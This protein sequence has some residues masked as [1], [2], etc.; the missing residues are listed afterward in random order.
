MMLFCVIYSGFAQI[1]IGSGT[2]EDQN[3]PFEPFYDY[4]YAQSIYLASEIGATGSITTVSFFFSGTTALPNS[5][6]LVLYMGHTAKTSFANAADFIPVANLTQVYTQTAYPLP[7]V[8]G[9]I[10]LTLT[11]PFAY[12]GTSNLVVAVDENAPG[13]DAITDDFRNTAV[14]GNR[15]VYFFRDGTDVLPTDPANAAVSLLSGVASFVPNIIFG[16]IA[17]ACPTPSMVVA[18]SVTATSATI[19]WTETSL[20]T[21]GYDYIVSTS[22]ITPGAASTATASSLTNP[23]TLTGLTPNTNYFIYVRRK[24][25]A[26]LNSAWSGAGTFRTLC[27][28]ITNLPWAEGFD[29]IVGGTD[30]FPGCWGFTNI[31]SNWA[32]STSPTPH[33][34]TN[35]LRRT[36]ST[37]GWAYTPNFSLTAGTAYEFSYWLRA[38]DTTAPGYFID[39]AVGAS[40][41]AA[42]MTN[43][44]DSKT[45]YVN[46]DWTKVTILFTPTTTGNYVF[47]IRAGTSSFAPNGINF[48]SFKL[49]T[50]ST[51][52]EPTGLIV[53]G[54]T[55][56]GGQVDWVEPTTPAALGYQYIITTTSTFPPASATPTGSVSAG[57]NSAIFSGLMPNT[58]YFVWVRSRCSA[59]N[60]GPWSD[61]R[62]FLTNCADVTTFSQNF[63]AGTTFPACWKKL[64][65]G[66]SAFIAANGQSTPNALNIS[67][68]GATVATQGLV[69]MPPVSNAGAGTHRLR[70]RARGHFAAGSVIQV[71]YVADNFDAS[72]FV[73]VQS[74]TTTSTTI[75]DSFIAVLGTAPGTNKFL[76]F[77]NSGAPAN[78]TILLDDVSW[79][80][81]PNCIEPTSVASSNVT[82]NSAV[83]SWIEPLVPAGSGYE[84]FTST[85]NTTPSAASV[86]T[87]SVGAGIST[88]TITSLAP[89][90]A[91]FV[92]VRSVCSS[93]NKSPWTPSITFTTLCAPF[94]TLNQDFATFRPACFDFSGAGTLAS[95]PTGTSLGLWEADGFLNAGATGAVKIN[96]YFTNRIGWMISP[97]M[98][99]TSGSYTF[100]FNYGVTTWNQT[101]PSPMG[102]DDSV[103]VLITTNGGTTWSQ[104]NE[105]T[106]ASNVS[107]TANI[108]SY[109]VP[110]ASSTANVRFA[111]LASDGTVDDSPDYDFFVDNFRVQLTPTCINPT[112]VVAS[113]ITS[114]AASIAWT[115]PSPAPASGYEYFV[116]TTNATPA[117]TATPTGSTSAGV[118][119][120][121]LTTL[122]AATTYFVWVRSVCTSSDKSEWSLPTTFTTLC[123]AV[124]TF[125][126]NFDAAAT[127][128]T[129][130]AKVGTS[131]TAVIVTSG[132]AST[133]N[134]L[135]INSSSATMRAVVSMP[136]V[137]NINAGTHWLRFKARSRFSVGGVIEVGYLTNTSN[138]ASF[139][140]IQSFTTTSTTV[141]N[142]FASFLGTPPATAILAFRHTGIPAN[143]VLID[144]VSWELL[145]ACSEPTGLVSSNV[146]ATTATVSWTASASVPANGYQYFVSTTNTAPSAS[147]TPTGSTAAGVTSVN[148]TGLTSSTNYFVWVRSVCSGSSTSVWTLSPLTFTT[149]CA[150]FTTLNQNFATFPPQCIS[151]AGAGTVATGP[152]GTAPGIWEADGF[153]N[154]GAAGA[155]KVNLYSTNRIGWMISPTMNLTGGNYTLSFDYGV[156]TWNQ[157]TP[158]TMGS[159]DSV[160]VVISTN[161]GT[162]WTQIS[163]FTA[164]SNVSNV[165]NTYTYSIPVAS[166]TNNVRFA[167][168]ATDG[169][170]AD[171]QDYDFFVDNFKVEIALSNTTFDND[172]FVSY[173]NPVKDFLNIG[174][175]QS[176]TNVEVFNLLGQRVITKIVNANQSKIDMSG[177]NAG[178]Y[179]V[180]VTADSQTKTIKVIK[181]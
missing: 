150:V 70:F 136:P 10:T 95:G 61:S 27:V 41:T 44:L 22:A 152:T 13:Y 87:G 145:P 121:S 80:L 96:L 7:V 146:A 91:Y 24:C 149:P 111:L 75:Y 68:S 47:G 139:V 142:N 143:D 30:V 79:E 123:T 177:L 8:P 21:L 165:S 48:D 138:D 35:L 162:S 133:P 131:G 18:S 100:S 92:W 147:A 107:N 132:G 59:S 117:A 126:Q 43:I 167:L 175:N 180:K 9:W 63:D 17:Q 98:N 2:N 11:T 32:T 130:W 33:A 93:S 155:V 99:L 181:E 101:T 81:I 20:A 154:S 82:S 114:G 55:N 45:G 86:A 106:A 151:F 112:A 90:T 102:S 4:S 84:Y 12:N 169:A 65:A 42:A 88:A 153:L 166:A 119:N 168:L 160:K 134:G 53:T 97:T 125:T 38:N 116:S 73:S 135:G 40:Q 58:N 122:N 161:G 50:V 69:V 109:Q 6:N 174:Y 104:I 37:E 89:Q 1:Q 51:C 141:Y 64:G 170:V 137:N 129:C 62:S 163:E 176:I 108:Y 179:L 46:A 28:P 56:S 74:F 124:A 148:L 113:A 172:N 105:F 31:T 158:S 140:S 60:T 83:I 171:S 39:T 164:A 94:T 19:G 144:D 3:M 120:V 128:P 23:F 15:S 66:G 14:T 67:S 34:G 156:T 76:A 49:A 57:N 118:T 29:D 25:S 157:T 85:T 103:K 5:Q 72:T 36:W 77:R 16:G 159:D 71:G 127:F 78:A 178:T 115:A 110:A 54:I 26:T 173:P 52:P